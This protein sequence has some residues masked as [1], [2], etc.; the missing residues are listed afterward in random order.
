MP[1]RL[2]WESN[3]QKKNCVQWTTFSSIYLFSQLALNGNVSTASSSI[4]NAESISTSLSDLLD[5][6]DGPLRGE[7]ETVVETWKDILRYTSVFW[8][9][10]SLLAWET[11]KIK[12]SFLPTTFFWFNL[13]L[14]AWNVKFFICFK[15]R[16]KMSIINAT[17]ENE[18]TIIEI[19]ESNNLI[20][21]QNLISSRL[22]YF[23]INYLKIFTYLLFAYLSDLKK[24]PQ[25]KK[26]VSTRS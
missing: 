26:K 11:W 24:N 9:N 18:L 16:L 8:I 15:F 6:N 19:E 17:C 22:G 21:I 20:C 3:T 1:T 12:E 14:I 2:T 4:C 25:S 10:C 7:S 13:I 5:R 23:E